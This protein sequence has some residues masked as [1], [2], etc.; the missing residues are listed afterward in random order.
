MKDTDRLL[1]TS[2]LTYGGPTGIDGLPQLFHTAVG[3][4][5]ICNDLSVLVTVFGT[6]VDDV[7]AGV[8]ARKCWIGY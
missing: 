6:G 4:Q 7:Q 1:K 5:F 8:V 3:L 2:A